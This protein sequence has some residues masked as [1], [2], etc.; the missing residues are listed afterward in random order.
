ILWRKDTGKTVIWY[1][2]ADGTYTYK[3]ISTLSTDWTLH[4]IGDV[5]M[6]GNTDILWR[7]GSSNYLWYMHADGTHTYKN[8]GTKS[9]DYVVVDGVSNDKVYKSP[10]KI[11]PISGK[12]YFGAIPSFVDEDNIPLEEE[13]RNIIHDFDELS[14][15]DTSWVY[16]SDNW[17][18]NHLQYPKDKINMILSTNKI[19]FVRMMPIKGSSGVSPMG[20][21]AQYNPNKTYPL[22]DIATNQATISQIRAWAQAAKQ[23]Y[24]ESKSNGKPFYLMLDFAP[25]MNGYWFQWGGAHQNPKEYVAAYQKIIDIFREEKVPHVTWVFHP[26]LTNMPWYAEQKKKGL[27]NFQK[28]EIWAEP[29]KYYPGDKYIDWVGVSIYG[30]DEYM[31]NSS[32]DY[33]P[34]FDTKIAIDENRIF[35]FATSKPRIVAELGVIENPFKPS[36]KATWFKNALESIQNNNKIYAFTY[37]NQS[38]NDDN[39]NYINMSIDSSPEAKTAFNRG[40]EKMNLVND[41]DIPN[42][43]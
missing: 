7:K 20:I 4:A 32:D 42:A 26:V 3:A 31:A 37:W 12:K 21:D 5:D 6:D 13:G 38:W 35:N 8:I 30:R 11:L 16:M 36:V 24:E 39:N 17:G 28:Y 14:G 29:S 43:E 19:P 23:H 33:Y 25:E 10:Y 1:M 34:S 15:Q 40:L 27:S 2:N 9:V 18:V 41:N 22:K